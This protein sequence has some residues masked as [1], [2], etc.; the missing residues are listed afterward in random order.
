VL[1][2][3]DDVKIN[4]SPS[5]VAQ[6]EVPGTSIQARNRPVPARLQR[7]DRSPNMVF[8]NHDVEVAMAPRLGAEASVDPVTGMPHRLQWLGSNGARCWLLDHLVRAREE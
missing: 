7:G 6:D 5:I 3:H 4:L 2:E 1:I 8:L